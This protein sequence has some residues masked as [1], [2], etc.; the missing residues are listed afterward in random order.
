MRSVIIT[1][2]NVCGKEKMICHH[3]EPIITSLTMDEKKTDLT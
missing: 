2:G 1:T 3:K